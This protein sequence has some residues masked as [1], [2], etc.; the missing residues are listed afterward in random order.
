M[1]RAVPRTGY[2]AI[3]KRTFFAEPKLTD[4][5]DDNGGLRH[6]VDG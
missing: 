3:S 2:R 5:D 6:P 4:D 1:L